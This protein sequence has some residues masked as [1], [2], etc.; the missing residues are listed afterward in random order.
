VIL[1]FALFVGLA[2][3]VTWVARRLPRPR[4]P[5]LALAVTNLG[6]PGGLTRSVVVSLG[7]GLSLLVAVALCD[8]ALV[9]ELT[10]R[11][12]KESPAY[13]VLDIP[14]S[15]LQ[16]FQDLVTREVP[17]ARIEDAPMLRG[18]L[19]ALEGRPTEEI[20]A[21]PEAQWVL[22]G[23]RGLTYADSVPEGSKLVAGDWWAADYSGPPLVS[24]ERELAQRL[25]LKIGD[26]IT[27][28]I[29]GR[30]VTARIANLRDVQWQSLGINFVMVFSPNTMRGA[31]HNLLATI[32]LPPS[33]GLDA[34]AR[35][36]R[37]LAR[38]FPSAT[39]IRVKDALASFDAILAKVLP[40]PNGAAYS[41][42]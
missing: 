11:L 27:V 3:L 34:E 19:V 4:Q 23:D 26:E 37:A 31:P 24:F 17:G 35:L 41:R 12:P 30:N 36:A 9:E 7:A 13:F 33:A 22:N 32:T 20:Q 18:R 38:S 15:E 6:A 1:V 8:A 25:G 5:E 16:D 29:L 14:K 10:G 40:P 28:N 2:A 21:P 42:P 39:P